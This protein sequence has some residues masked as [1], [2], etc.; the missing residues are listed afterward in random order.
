MTAIR[1]ILVTAFCQTPG[2]ASALRLIFPGAEVYSRASLSKKDATPEDVAQLLA[3]ID[4]W[5]NTEA[6]DNFFS[7]AAFAATHPNLRYLSLPLLEFAAFHPDLC[8]ARDRKGGPARVEYTSAIAVWTYKSGLSPEKGA[9][10]YNRAAFANLGYLSEWDRSA[11]HLRTIFE[12][13]SL[14]ADFDRF[15]LGIKR[16]GLFMYSATHP[17]PAV[18]AILAKLI[19]MK[20]GIDEAALDVDVPALDALSHFIWPVYPEI[21]QS[22]SLPSS[23]YVWQWGDGTRVRGL[24]SFLAYSYAQ[25]KAAG[26][27][28]SEIAIPGVDFDRFSRAVMSS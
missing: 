10:L 9:R 6:G 22:L 4:V 28:P 23:G 5:I 17:R 11:A 7:G 2:L 1:R 15:Y 25:Y 21:A 19:A 16:L 12:A 27:G 8:A 24:E 14:A 13:T 20:L 18:L 3:Q 26:L